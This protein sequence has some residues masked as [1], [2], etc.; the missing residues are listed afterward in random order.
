MKLFRKAAIDEKIFMI[1][2][3]M[4]KLL[5]FALLRNHLELGAS[6]AAHL[7]SLLNHAQCVQGQL[8]NHESQLLSLGRGMKK[9][10]P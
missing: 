7:L 2:L 3:H 1:Q 9:Q 4:Q 10:A 8:R 5:Q 6:M